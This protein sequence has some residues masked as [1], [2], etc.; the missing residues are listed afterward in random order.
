MIQLITL[1]TV[2]DDGKLTFAQY[3]QIPF[4]IQRIYYIYD[5][6][7]GLPR[8]AHAH[9][10]TQQV[11]FCLR[12]TV[13]I[14]LDNGKKQKTITLDDPKKGIFL[15]KLIWH[16]MRNI[17]QDTFMLVLASKVYNPHDYIR[18]YEMFLK[19]VEK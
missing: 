1:P 9:Y 13:D 5:C 14:I 17:N 7:P 2:V 16:D 11:L 15:D 10:Q 19:E 18:N 12:G 4:K 6:T 3:P 8:G